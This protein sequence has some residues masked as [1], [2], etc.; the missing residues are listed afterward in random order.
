MFLQIL[1][2][3]K[4][5]TNKFNTIIKFM[6]ILYNKTDNF[7]K[8]VFFYFN[9]LDNQSDAK[10]IYPS[11]EEL[12]KLGYSPKVIVY[13]DNKP[14]L[15]PGE[16][17]SQK[18]ITRFCDVKSR[19]IRN[20]HNNLRVATFNVHNFISR[21]NQGLA[22]LF[23]NLL[24]PFNSS[25]DIT[26]FIKLI[27]SLDCDVICLQEFVPVIEKKITTDLTDL[28]YI[29]DNFN[30]SYFLDCFIFLFHAFFYMN[31]V[32][33]FKFFKLKK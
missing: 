27:D 4:I 7:K 22:P 25:R 1:E 6:I 2:N 20:K 29:R 17:F 3:F 23:G 33:V 11:Q 28:N 19:E 10:F 32:T 9:I 5:I 12:I 8:N 14:Y 16:D 18:S 30:F 15:Y 21:C 31:L 13:S 26:K 24:N